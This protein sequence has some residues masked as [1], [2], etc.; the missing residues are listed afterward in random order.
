M[1]YSQI[2]THFPQGKTVEKSIFLSFPQATVLWEKMDKKCVT[3]GL[4]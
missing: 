2:Y 3:I 4:Q 1:G